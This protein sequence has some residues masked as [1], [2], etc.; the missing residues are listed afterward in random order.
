MCYVVT[1]RKSNEL[2]GTRG[3]SDS[4]YLVYGELSTHYISSL[5]YGEAD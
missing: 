4:H 1:N 5:K 2:L 3:A